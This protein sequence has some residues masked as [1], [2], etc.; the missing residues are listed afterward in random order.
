MAT[1]QSDGSIILSTKVDTSGMEK[2]TKSLKSQAAKLAAEYRKAGM[3]QSEAFKKAW[4]EIDRT[5]TETEKA[6]K[7]TKTYGEKSKQAI[8]G[9]SSALKSLAGYLTAYLSVFALVRFS[10]E[11]STMAMNTEASV[12]RIVDIFGDASDKVGDFI[13]QN[14]EALALSKSAAASFAS[15]YGNL[16]SVFADANVNAEL[17]NRYLSMTA[18]VASK[19]GRTME[20]VQE[21]IRSGLLGN[22]EAVEDLGIFVNVKTIEMSDAFKRVADGRSWDALSAYEQSQVRAMAILE[23]ATAKYGDTMAKTSATNKA[24][25]QAAF[26]DFQNTWG[27]LINLVLVPVLNVLT[28]IFKIAT[29][30][31]NAMLGRSGNILENAQSQTDSIKESVENQEALTDEVKETDKAL[32]KTLASFDD[33]QILTSKS[34]SSETANSGGLLTDVESLGVSEMSE[35]TSDG[36]DVSKTLKD[37][38]Q[39]LKD[40]LP[41]I[42]LS[43][44]AIGLILVAAGNLPWGIGFIVGGAYLYSVTNKKTG[45]FNFDDIKKSIEVLVDIIPGALVTIG[46]ILL[47]LGNIPWGIGFIVAGAAI[48]SVREMPS[49]NDYGDKLDVSTQLMAIMETVAVAL[50]AIGLL[51]LFIGHALLGVGFIVAGAAMLNVTEAQLE[52]KNLTTDLQDFFKEYE[53]IIK[54]VAWGILII[55][56]ILLVSG[57]AGMGV[58]LIAV[59]ATALVVNETVNND[60][61]TDFKTSISNFFEENKT[62]IIG[63]AAAA[64]VLGVLLL[65]NMKIAMGIKLIAVGAGVLAG[66]D[67]ATE[68]GLGEMIKDFI[69]DNKEVIAGI[70]AGMVV[71]GVVLLISGITTTFPTAVALIAAGAT[72]LVTVVATNWGAFTEKM[73]GEMG[74]WTAIVSG[75]LLVLG[76]ILLFTGVGTALGVSLILAGAAGLVTVVAINWDWL[77]DAIGDVCDAIGDLF[78]SMINAVLSAFEGLINGIIWLFESLVNLIISGVNLV[79]EGINLITGSV[80]DLVGVNLR[81]PTLSKANFGRIKLPKLAEGAVIPANHE[82]LA[83]LGD[84][85]KG[86]NIEAPLSTIEEAVENVLSKRGGGGSGQPITVILEVDK[87]ELGRVSTE[88]V[89]S[90]LSLS[91]KNYVQ[92]RKV[93]LA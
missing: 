25:F 61:N 12:Q 22:T 32:G 59:G 63:I 16:F 87:R 34:S 77:V 27:Q 80:G 44:V 84:Q 88:A 83:V 18:V 11:A 6:T 58:K 86:T 3:S 9:V 69:E 15:V 73:R 31:L 92:T 70:S 49:Q 78:T 50:V 48:Y 64:L 62:I 14:A 76:V 74:V 55:G 5:R 29:A 54:G 47:F 7:T 40:F 24:E 10:K 21:R 90:E 41:I 28:Q 51:L 37:I 13:D 39:A 2:G 85:K 8:L 43:L 93:V 67:A 65:A 23:Q 19:T 60:G 30:G 75:A 35:N 42:E 91:G 52:K 71:L 81:I 68:G 66:T 36:S 57:A 45:D 38:E 53:S 82:F 4:S 33:L 72:G 20:D 1:P 56:I 17:T 26:Q 79:V 89:A 46:I